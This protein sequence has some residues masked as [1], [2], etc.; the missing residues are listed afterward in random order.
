MDERFQSENI[1]AVE[2]AS[3]VRKSFIDYAMS[4]I[5]DRALPDVRDGLKPVHRR[6]LYAM[7]EDGLTSTKP[8]RK[9]ATTVGNVL[10]HYHPHGD[11]S[12]YNAMVR[13]AQP[14]SLRYPLV[15]GHGNF[16]NIDGDGAAAYRYTEARLAKMADEML[17]DIEKDVVDFIPNFDNKQK[18]PVVLPSRFPNLLVNGSV[19]IAVGMA[20]N[21]PPHNLNEVIDGAIHYMYNPDCEVKDLMKFIKGPDFPTYATI[22]G[23][24]GIYQMY[25]TGKGRVVVRSK[26]EIEEGRGGKNSIIIT[27]IPYGVN[28]SE[29]VKSI[30]DLAH[31]KRVEGI[32]DVRDESSGLEGI[33]IVVEVRRDTN[34]NVVLNKLY[35]YTQLQSNFAANM[36]ALVNGEPKTLTLKQ[37]LKHYIDHQKEV[38]ER[39]IRFNLEKA[40]RRAHILE[41]LKIAIDNIDEVIK[42]IRFTPGGIPEV[43]VKLMERF[44]LSE[45][46]ATEI[47]Q[48]PLGRLSGLEIDKILDELDA[49]LAKIKE[50]EEI[51]ASQNGISDI[52]RDEMLEIKRKYG[53]ERRTDIEEV[54]NEILIEDLIDRKDCAVTISHS[55]YVKRIPVD[56]YK[57]QGRGGKGN[58]TMKTKEED[59]V[60]SV[61]IANTHNYLMLF[62]NQGRV[63]MKKCYEIPEASKNAKGTNFVNIIEL[64]PDE[65]VTAYLSIE[66]F[67]SKPYLTMI[68]K[69]GVIKRTLL[70]SYKNIR[71]SGLIA[72]N[73]DENDELLYVLRTDGNSEMLL[74]THKGLSVHFNEA[75][76][77]V[78][79]RTARGV[80]AIELGD[81]DLVVG[82]LA[83]DK[84]DKRDVLLISETGIGKR[85]KL[86]DFP[87]RNRGGKGVICHK[88]TPKTGMLAGIAAVT[89]QDDVMI[90]TNSGMVIR[91]RV[92]EIPVHYRTAQGVIIMRLNADVKIVS[93][94][95]MDKA[96]EEPESTEGAE[97][98]DTASVQENTDNN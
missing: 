94:T 28:K 57:V 14:F 73:L 92:S 30:A 32:T 71:R 6:I 34:A 64:A 81:D 62:T 36:L 89:E 86:S 22:H 23:T 61:I 77:R 40:K 85:A 93:F 82:A 11:S 24:S 39:R 72:I 90:V 3:E 60:Q 37:I 56:E 51:L 96:S 68:T 33:R 67:A 26:A 95:R 59:F 7:Y 29:L 12:V 4:V 80:K 42:I 58:V 25:A 55:G 88:V 52:V 84:D 16:G 66:D 76:A 50:F 17:V 8:F 49:V 63:F 15:E 41:G 48:M 38:V 53:D 98:S 35:S 78:I 46:Q 74:A 45:I 5:I 87:I 31:E 83:F 10:G 18:E 9:S 97:A 69:N 21:I 2:I 44:D 19:G 70:E 65:K 79:G 1:T 75:C 47:V 91:T 43:K 20:T 13:L 27:E 54:E